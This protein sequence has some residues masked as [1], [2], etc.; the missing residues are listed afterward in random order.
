MKKRSLLLLLSL[1]VLLCFGGCGKDN[2]EAPVK[3]S[4]LAETIEDHSD[5]ETPASDTPEE[6][7]V[8]D[9]EVP[10]AEGMVRSDVTNEWIDEEVA[11][12]VRRIY[13]DVFY[14]V[15]CIYLK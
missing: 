2:D 9:S 1:S 6:S 14:F 8:E 7:K 3:P 5:V 4:D 15:F 11:A 12:V 13:H 10:P